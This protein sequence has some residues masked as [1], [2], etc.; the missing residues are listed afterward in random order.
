MVQMHQRHRAIFTRVL[1]FVMLMLA[2]P[3]SAQSVLNGDWNAFYHED[4]PDRAPGPDPVDYTGLPINAAGR[5]YADSWDASRLTLP[6]HQC[7]AHV[8]PYI[9]RGPVRVRISEEREPATQDVVAIKLFMSTWAQERTIWL[10]GRPHPP[11][12]APHTWMG[13]ST[14]EWQGSVLMVR[15][16]H[17]KQGWHRRNGVPMSAQTTMTEFFFRHGTLLTQM[18]ITDDPVFL[19]EPLVKTTN[20]RLDPDTQPGD[21]QR[22]LFCQAA[23]EV[24]GRDPAYVPHYLP[25]ENPFLEEFAS[26]FGVAVEAA[27]GG[28]ETMYPDYME[29]VKKMPVPPPL[30]PAAQQAR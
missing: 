8:S 20:L 3:A 17:I 28:A 5:Q 10:D 7:R 15:T 4:E 1:V 2:A 12:Y 14:G 27:R 9:L 16:T 13:F 26:R 21:Y 18:S 29:K 25:G 11:A 30:P 22:W 6:E 24:A 23:E 19:D